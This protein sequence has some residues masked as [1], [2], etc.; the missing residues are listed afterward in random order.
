MTIDGLIPNHSMENL[1]KNA[2]FLGRG[3]YAFGL[4]ASGTQQL[5]TGNFVRLVPPLPKG[6]PWPAVWPYL[7]GFGLI[8]FGAILLAPMK[9][10]TAATCVGA[11]LF[12]SF[13]FQHLPAIT[14]APSHGYTW[15]NPL[16]VLAL[17]GGALLLFADGI[18]V[19]PAGASPRGRR[20]TLILLGRILFALFLVVGGVQHFVYADFVDTLIPG[21]IPK[22]R[23][24][25]YFAGGALIAGGAGLFVP[26]VRRLAALLSGLMIFLW[27]VLLHIPRAFAD[28]ANAG[29]TSA[30]F[31]ALALSGVAFLVARSFP[32]AEETPAELVPASSAFEYKERPLG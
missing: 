28:T 9:S 12:L 27:V 6:V 17:L 18:E 16:K 13:L 2:A 32:L 23:F 11:M 7:V 15:T 5:L 14:A 20:E 29:E 1:E 30:I 8:V 10:R 26:P 25:T 4:I 22:P 24:W 21:W 3:F 19:P 31:E